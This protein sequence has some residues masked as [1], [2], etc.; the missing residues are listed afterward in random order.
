ME[1]VGICSDEDDDWSKAEVA[2]TITTITS[3]YSNRSDRCWT[4]ERWRREK[5]GKYMKIVVVCV[6][7]LYSPLFLRVP[8]TK[9]AKLLKGTIVKAFFTLLG[10]EG[11]RI[12]IHHTMGSIGLI[13][14]LV[15]VYYIY[16]LLLS[17]PPPFLSILLSVESDADI[18]RSKTR[19]VWLNLWDHRL[20]G[21][22][23][24]TR[25][26]HAIPYNKTSFERRAF[27]R[28]QRICAV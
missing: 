21:I 23:I 10:A 8:R 6:R 9:R 16:P 27:H 19:F 3:M 26:Q 14:F 1:Y 28:Y 24:E 11:Q 5:R 25:T 22:E 18:E 15:F 12:S 13:N 2:K 17:P 20:F 4:I 7:N